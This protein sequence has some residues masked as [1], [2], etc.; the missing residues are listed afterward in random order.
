MRFFSKGRLRARTAILLRT[1]DRPLFLR[2]DNPT[3]TG[4]LRLFTM[5]AVILSLK[6]PWLNLK[7]A[8]R[9]VS[10]L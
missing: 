3:K 9:G 10:W 6:A 7:V 1:K 4:A 2:R 8:W 5:A